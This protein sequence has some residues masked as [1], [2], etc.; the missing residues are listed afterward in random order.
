[1]KKLKI[2]LQE[3]MSN[4]MT[5]I[6]EFESSI[7]L[8]EEPSKFRSHLISK[9]GAYSLDHPGEKLVYKNVFPELVENLQESFRKEQEKHI[10]GM[11]SAI[12][13]YEKELNSDNKKD[14]ESYASQI[15][16]EQRNILE[17]VIEK[18]SESY[19]NNKLTAFS[20][21]KYVIKENYSS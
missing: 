1:M 3:S 6:K 21:V 8:K 20:L 12:V 11:A 18:I 16:A 19:G 13:F 14:Q 9:L 4:Q 10:K 2:Q 7:N 15:S 5:F 17:N